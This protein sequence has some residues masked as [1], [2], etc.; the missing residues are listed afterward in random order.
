MADTDDDRAEDDKILEE[1]RKRFKLCE[2]HE[3]DARARFIEDVKFAEGDST[4]LWQ[5]DQKAYDSRTAQKKPALT[6]N[7][8]REHNLQILNDQRQNKSQIKIRPVGGG[9]T[10]KAAEV[11]EGIVRHIEYQSRALEAYDAG[12]YNQ[13]YGGWGYW[14]IATDYADAESFDQEIFIRRQRDPLS[15]YLDPDIQEF[16]GSDAR[17]GFAFRDYAR[18][19]FELDYPSWRDENT[20]GGQPLPFDGAGWW[21]KDH[22]RVAEY[23]RRSEE[24]DT[25]LQLADGAVILA[26][27][28]PEGS[29]PKRMKEGE[30]VLVPTQA[31]IVPTPIVRTREVVK[32]TVEW[33]KIAGCKAVERN[34]WL[35]SYIPLVRVVGEETIIE[36]KLDRKGHTRALKDPQRMYNWYS[37]T[38]V[39]YAASQT[40]TPFIGPAKAFEGVETFW[41][42]AN[43][44]A[45]PFLPY[46]H[47]DDEGQ[48]IPAPSRLNPPMSHSAAMD[49]MKVAQMEM[50]M[51]S[52]QYQSQFGEN[53]NAKS[54]IAIQTR[55]RQGDN[56]TYHYIDH[57]A[58]AIEFTGRQLIELIPKV[59]DT[60]RIIKIMAE[61][62]TQSEVKIDPNGP[63]Y[64]QRINGQ[65]ATEEQ[66]ETAQNDPNLKDQ[67]ETIFNPNVGKY[68]VEADI[69]PAF[70]T[71]RQEGFAAMTEL[72]KMNPEFMKIGGDLY[73]RQADF[74]LADELAERFKRAIPPAIL[75]EGEPPAV[76]QIKQQAQAQ[77]QQ[78]QQAMSDLIK[79]N[80]ER[81]QKLRDR[82]AE[83]ERQQY[84]AETRRMTAIGQI[85]PE[86]FKPVIRQLVS[87]ALGTPIV[88]LMGAHAAAESMHMPAPPMPA[89]QGDADGDE[90]GAPSF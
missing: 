60:P 27:K 86:A 87:E 26:S 49:G 22:V 9:A 57:L 54:G 70:N 51:A 14:R 43:L 36:G 29:A 25:L 2:D 40:Q 32:P 85:D 21:D 83:L 62:G 74:P 88:P 30:L 52:G 68:D 45:R 63:A 78:L 12:A 41:N 79:Q 18:E 6:I 19:Q 76:A 38:A 13:I 77:V 66:V 4:N 84:E 64:E 58:Q 31:G 10:Y 3:K 69:G 56:A 37:S 90:G 48:A 44:E 24:A 47:V 50:M 20:P 23:F 59:Y 81:E 75:G 72:A 15:I 33:F 80:A 11:F 16:D 7:K 89:K 39:E 46:N 42:G 65:P 34:T 82:E 5:W 61:D 35:G 8:T 53:E 71:R 73:F 1:A 28:L 55:Q 17:Y 67:I